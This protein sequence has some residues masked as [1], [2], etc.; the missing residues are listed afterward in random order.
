MKWLNSALDLHFSPSSV[1]LYNTYW[2]DKRSVKLA[3]IQNKKHGIFRSFTGESAFSILSGARNFS[4]WFSRIRYSRFS[5]PASWVS[6]V[7]HV[8][9]FQE[10][11]RNPCV[12]YGGDVPSMGRSRSFALE[13]KFYEWKQS[14]CRNYDLQHIN[15][16]ENTRR[17]LPD[18]FLFYTN[19]RR[20]I[21]LS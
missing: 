3:E 21:F 6:M 19:V 20:G 4:Y 7:T 1:V 2:L 8:G 14:H 9:G 13:F 16:K 12:G 15:L 10:S 17:S 18:K 5:L 11:I